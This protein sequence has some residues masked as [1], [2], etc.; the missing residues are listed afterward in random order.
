MLRHSA[1]FGSVTIALA[2][3]LT[4]GGC[5]PDSAAPEPAPL[6]ATPSPV[7]SEV[8]T[9]AE[10]T[11][12][13]ESIKRPSGLVY[14]T[15]KEGTGSQAKSHDKVTIHYIAAVDGGKNFDSTRE[16]NQPV[17]FE[18]G[19]SRFIQGWT[20]GITG[21]KAGE[22]RKL[23]VPSP[24]GYGALGRFPVI[25]PNSTLAL[26]IEMIAIGEPP[27]S[28]KTQS[29]GAKFMI[30]SKAQMD[31]NENE[32]VDPPVTATEKKK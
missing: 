17:T 31:V 7:D 8:P 30:P 32:W 3:V 15:L 4:M 11:K 25:P 16:R 12:V 6:P 27:P 29:L 26:D 20:E 28:L 2:A 23:T 22:R 24:L 18:L 9:I 13:G 1:L 19:D 14:E 10:P 21:M 5:T